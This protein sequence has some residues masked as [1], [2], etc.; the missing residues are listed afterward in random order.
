VKFSVS[1]LCVFS[2]LAVT[3]AWSQEPQQPVT[4][5]TTTPARPTV[6]VTAGARAILLNEVQKKEKDVQQ[7]LDEVKTIEKSLASAQTKEKGVYVASV[8]IAVFGAFVARYGLKLFQEGNKSS[9]SVIDLGPLF[10]TVGG[11]IVV[12][13]TA[14][15]AGDGVWI[16]CTHQ[17]KVRWE[18][19]LEK[20]KQKLTDNQGRLD[21][22][23]AQIKLLESLEK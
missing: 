19:A 22:M 1:I 20:A 8:P 6:N 23:K 16:Y 12:G 17:Q 13:G 7:A 21:E 4:D 11:A 14:I 9:S 15:I 18:E 2:I 5:H 10:W 3:P